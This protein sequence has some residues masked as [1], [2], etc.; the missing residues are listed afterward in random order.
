MSNTMEVDSTNSYLSE[1][2]PGYVNPD[3][4]SDVNNVRLRYMKVNILILVMN[5]CLISLVSQIFQYQQ[6]HNHQHIS[7]LARV[8]FF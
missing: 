8:I 7:F 3:P 6:H 4:M 2:S 5:V 1:T